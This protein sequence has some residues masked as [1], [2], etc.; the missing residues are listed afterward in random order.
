MRKL[1]RILAAMRANKARILQ[2]IGEV[3]GMA[4]RRVPDPEGDGSSS[5]TWFLPDAE[6]AGRFVAA[7]RA[8][9]IP[10]AQIYDGRPVYATP[11]I[12]ERRTASGKGGPW[13]CAEH[14]TSVA[15]RMG[16]C[17][18]TEDLVSRSVSI[19]VGAA[20]STVDCDDSAEAVRKVARH[21]L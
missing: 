4:R 20:F 21:L 2:G 19:A 8:E 1:P 18:R 6:L 3:P 17:P 11:S 14:P 7:L 15:Y 16:M 5:V 10:S 9:G 13:N 12:L